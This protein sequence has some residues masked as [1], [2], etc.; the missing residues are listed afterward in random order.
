MQTSMGANMVAARIRALFLPAG[1]QASCA[2]QLVADVAAQAGL[3]PSNAELIEEL[4][5]SRQRLVTAQDEARR[6]LERNIHDGAQ[7]DL[8]TLAVKLRLAAMA[9]PDGPVRRILDELQAD[10]AD[11]LGNLRDLARGVYPPLLA[12][13]GLAAA[14]QAQAV[15]SSL[16]VAVQARAVG[17][18]PQDAEAAVYFCCLEALQ[19]ST[20]HA[21]AGQARIWIRIQDGSLCFTVSDD[22]AGFDARRTPAGAGLRNMAD[23]LAA[24]GGRIE[25]RSAPGQGTAITGHLPLPAAVTRK[26]SA[27]TQ[28]AQSAAGWPNQVPRAS[29][30]A[31]VS[32]AS[33][34]AAHAT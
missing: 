22:G 33:A 6:R 8:V 4:R 1:N 29:R 5:A 25:I 2:G 17:R 20:K 31:P 26:A 14:L 34:A 24:L 11:A 18:L 16:P 12:E 9:V 32:W 30:S 27:I 3:V 10:A 7:Q 21:G 23:R 13:Q 19:N 15:K 28:V